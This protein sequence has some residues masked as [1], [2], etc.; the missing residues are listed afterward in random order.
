[1][2][3]TV[4]VSLGFSF[5]KIIKGMIVGREITMKYEK[6]AKD[7]LKHVGGRENINSV[8]H[9]ITRLRFQLKDEGK[10]IQKY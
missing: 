2:Y 4:M 3:R 9:C 7:I 10:Q 5:I 1:M 6:L 8:V